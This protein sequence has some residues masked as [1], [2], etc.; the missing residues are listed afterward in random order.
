MKRC[1]ACLCLVAPVLG[2]VLACGGGA[3]SVQAQ[4]IDR[5]GT[6]PYEVVYRP[7]SVS[8][9]VHEGERFDLIY[10]AGSAE[11]AHRTASAL[12][13]S[14]PGT[15]S[16]VGPVA[17][18]V[19]MPVV[20]NNF[21]DRSNG[22][23]DPVPFR[24]E[25]EA[26]SIKSNTLS[27]HAPS[28]PALV[29]PHEGVH[30]AHAEVTPG[31]GV[32]ALIRPFAPDAAR[33]LNLNAPAGLIEGAAVYRES[34]LA[35]GTGR[36]NAPL[37]TM[38]M[39]AALLSDD[40]W[41]FTQM[42]E[43]PAYTKPFDRHYIAGGHAFEYLAE[44]GDSVSTSFFS[45]TVGSYNRLPVIGHG[46]WLERATGQRP[47]ELRAEIRSH[48]QET[49]E[50]EL[51][52][53]A[54]F[55]KATVVAGARGRTH[56]RPYWLSDST[57]VAHVRGYETRPGFYRLSAETGTRTPLRIQSITEDYTYSLGP[58]TTALYASRYV[59]RPTVPKQQT[60]E[61]ERISLRDGSVRQ[62]TDGGRAFA[63]LKAESGSLYVST[64]DG[65]F[66][67][68][69]VVEEDGST[70]ALMPP[71][72]LR[73]R[74]IAPSPTDDRV[75]VLIQQ[76]GDQR[77]YRAS[78]PTPGERPPLRP[79]VDLRN[80]VIYDVSWGPEGRYLL[81]SGERGT[82]AN[83]Y[84]HDT[85]TGKTRQLT[86]VRFGAL[87][88][89]LSPDRSTLAFV[90]YRHERHDLVRM[91][92]RPRTATPL[93]DSAVRH[94]G[95]PLT[96]DHE[97]GGGD[98]P[99]ELKEHTTAYAPW[100][101]LAPRMVYPTLQNGDGT[102]WEGETVATDPLGL[103]IGVGVAGSDPLQQWAYR[104]RT[105]WQDGRLWGEAKLQS[106]GYL[107]RPSVSV[108]NRT[109]SAGPLPSGT[110][111]SAVEERGL[112]LGVRLP[113]SLRSNVYQS[114][115]QFRFDAEGRQTRRR[116]ASGEY[117]SR[118]TL[119]PGVGLAYRLQRNSRDVVPN[120][121]LVVQAQ[122]TLDAWTGHGRGTL[123]GLVGTDVYLP[124][125]RTSHTGLRLGAR[126]VAQRAGS[127]LNVRSVVPRG[128]DVGGLPGGTFLQFETE[129]T[130]PLWYIDDGVSLVPFYAKVLSIYG[131]GET[132]G[133]V[134]R[135]SW[136]EQLTSVGAGLS[137]EARFFYNF[138]LDL[139]VGVAY[140]PGRQAAEVI[141]R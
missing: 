104:A 102:E 35:P 29:G 36:L 50:E 106:G 120:T 134:R 54:P 131:F 81:F 60:A 69:S 101:H 34:R 1:V 121:G 86:N 56:R 15:D 78:A 105:W 74:Q 41:S 113:L 19:Q 76:E 9:R 89:A 55:T 51:E 17:D 63:P 21:T 30:A 111:R 75:A 137:L 115:L 96:F 37:F 132:L 133:R 16:L 68:W 92:F 14:W 118:V 79:W 100:Q 124:F 2:L 110:G 130:Q 103:G 24:Q 59:Q 90:R 72:P 47:G 135:G 42:M 80:G 117:T 77:L 31:V 6:R 10:Q 70:Q 94:G 5:V 85:K 13:E 138:E 87:E 52:Q 125:L 116:G 43:R 64:N 119:T 67:Q 66:S 93:P 44:R 114:A 128:Y 23:V 22:I 112:N 58:D 46:L 107:L 73:V 8:Y 140:Q 33:S 88:P 28:W 98:G 48:L 27:A 123:A 139:R 122:G 97:A 26:P 32:G 141:G 95:P 39:K 38:K 91:P 65:P 62:E 18:D 136:T 7:D 49:Y 71:A 57:L 4:A 61:V 126:L 84:V 53:R 25:I 45:R 109:F 40:P 127:V 3:S 11:M 99:A 12:R 108:Y 82:A 129:V 20:I 83:V